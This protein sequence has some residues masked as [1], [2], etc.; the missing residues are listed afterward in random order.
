MDPAAAECHSWAQQ[1]RTTEAW[2][3]ASP[4]TVAAFGRLAERLDRSRCVG[5]R[6]ATFS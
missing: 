1:G 5:A 3:F 4:G 6:I 2:I